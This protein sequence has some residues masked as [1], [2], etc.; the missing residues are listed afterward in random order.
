M[1]DFSLIPADDATADLD[2]AEASALEASDVLFPAE[3]PPEPFGRTPKFDFEA[4][5][6]VKAGGEPIWV[7][8]LD[9]LEQWCLMAI[10]SARYAHAV[11]TDEFG[12]EEPDSPLG[13]AEEAALVEVTDWGARMTEALLVHDRIAA[14][15]DFSARIED[16]VIY[17]DRFD[18]VTDEDERLRI[19]GLAVPVILEG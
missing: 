18:V 4:G 19:G 2:A 14:V 6:M 16:D 12:M 7:T 8:G 3:D 13:L 5:R 1:S 15:E 17:I 10:Y 11:F 9:A